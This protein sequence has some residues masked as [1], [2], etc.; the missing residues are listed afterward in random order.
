MKYKNLI[1]ILFLTFLSFSSFIFAQEDEKIPPASM[2]TSGKAQ[3]FG[4]E[5]YVTPVKGF[6]YRFTGQ[7]T[8]ESV[9]DTR[10][11]Q[12]FL[13]DA[14][15][16]FPLPITLDPRRLDVFDKD[17]LTFI[18]LSASGKTLFVGPK[19]WG[20]HTNGRID[21]SFGGLSNPT[22]WLTRLSNAYINFIWRRSTELRIGHYYHPMALAKVYPT[23]V[24][25]N[26]GVGYDPN[27]KAP[28]FR[29]RHNTGNWKFVL[30]IAKQFN[31][32]SA[33][34]A[35]LP[36]LFFQ[37]N[38]YK[39][40]NMYGSGVCYRAEVP[41]IETDLGYKTTEQLNMFYAFVFARIIKHPFLIKARI[42]YLENGPAFGTIGGYAVSSLNAAT[43]DRTLV[44]L[45]NI[46]F[47]TDMVYKDSKTLE[48]GLFVGLSKMLGSSS[49]IIKC[50]QD[51]DGTE[52]S[53]LSGITN[54]DYMF[55]F[56]PRLRAVFKNLILGF[57][58]EYSRA[59]FAR[60]NTGTNPQEGWQEDIDDYGR[61]VNTQAVGN[62]GFFFTA[63]YTF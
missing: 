4:K 8:F 45:R 25:G 50:Y 23:T 21:F 52:I 56:A 19:I 7:V 41:R 57:E 49:K 58:V 9:Y 54:V 39:D 12:G 30:A 34:W 48:P 40:E 31:S 26:E 5:L 46:T 24:S 47:W 29:I 16:F 17:Q 11:F 62:T 3:A 13:Q 43:D 22:V 32:E 51:N 28:I 20:A 36:D 35:A 38:F 37:L 27:R 61:L 10:Q 33:R 6:G 60:Q 44:P 59:S 42:S 14:V 15:T 2:R 55:V 53:L 18:G 1:S 63:S